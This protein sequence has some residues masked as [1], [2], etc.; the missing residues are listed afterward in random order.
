MKKARLMEPGLG[1]SDQRCGARSRTTLPELRASL[2]LLIIRT[3]V[4]VMIVVAF[5]SVLGFEFCLKLL[6]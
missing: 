6:D 1:G 2:A 5:C 4:V 3:I